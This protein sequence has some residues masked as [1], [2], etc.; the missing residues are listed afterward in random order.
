MVVALLG[1]APAFAALDVKSPIPLNTDICDRCGDP[2]TLDVPLTITGAR[3]ADVRVRVIDVSLGSRR[4]V[5]FKQAITAVGIEGLADGP[6][7]RI[8][9][10]QGH[11]RTQGTYTVTVEFTAKGEKPVNLALQLIRP[12]ASVQSPGTI[13][14]DRVRGLWWEPFEESSKP[15]LTLNEISNRAGLTGVRVLP[16]TPLAGHSIDIHAPGA[17]D[18]NSTE[19]A[20]SL[21]VPPGSQRCVPYTVKGE[22]P[23]GSHSQTY[24][25]MAAELS[26]PVAITFEVRSRLSRVYVIVIAA[27]GV[28]FGLLIKVLLQRRIEVEEARALALDLLVKVDLDRQAQK[29]ETFQSQIAGHFNRLRL[30]VD[31]SDVEAMKTA[32]TDLD[33][34]WRDALTNLSK[35]R[36]EV[37]DAL[38][39]VR[40]IAATP[41]QVPAEVA[42]PI[43]QLQA[44]ID[45]VRELLGSGL[46][47]RARDVL[48]AASEAVVSAASAA[49]TEWQDVT[50]DLFDFV[51]QTNTGLSPA[52]VNVVQE[53]VTA[54]DISTSKLLQRGSTD[55]LLQALTA[56]AEDRRAARRI[57]RTLNIGL[58]Q[59]V[60][61]AAGVLGRTA[62]ALPGVIAAVSG[63]TDLLFRS[64]DRPSADVSPLRKAFGGI[65]HEW[66]TALEAEFGGPLP[67]PTATLLNE[68]RYVDAAT[69][70]AAALRGEADAAPKRVAAFRPAIVSD[71]PAAGVVTF[72]TTP[73]PLEMP[74]PL[75]LLQARTRRQIAAAKLLQTSLVAVFAMIVGY[76]LF[77][78]KFI[79]DYLDFVMIFFWAFGLDLT[80]DAIA[81]LAPTTRK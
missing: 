70:V 30:A 15:V 79:G 10:K 9:I 78:P 73:T 72:T 20:S 80:A 1:G 22:F 48:S 38:D 6:V 4:E 3:A 69:A 37:Q 65:Q 31:G 17:C 62:D 60:D 54:T 43:V 39:K 29:D 66:R 77:A 5:E 8:R 28:L 21:Q 67:A 55:E 12:P 23:L 64:I 14:V 7:L 26:A 58:Q 45:R 24:S 52:M 41:W 44:E 33:K 76:G 57:V 32:R 53:A 61:R 40:S 2:W 18:S 25:L 35:R 71:D 11:L 68:C 36:Q 49:I 27:A 19:P 59:E 16:P 56:A 63:L 42:K 34:T 51:R 50:R 46:V 81:K 47:T 75:A 13:V 74:A